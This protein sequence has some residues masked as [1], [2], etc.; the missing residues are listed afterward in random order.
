MPLDAGA[1]TVMGI[2]VASEPQRVQD[3]IA[4]MPQRFGLYEDLS[5]REN[6]DLY[7]SLHGISDEER[8]RRY[9]E[10]LQMTDLAAF[11]GRLAGNLSGGMKQKLRSCLYLN[12]LARASAAG[13]TDGRRRSAVAPRIVGNHRAPRARAKSQRP[14]EHLVSRRS[15]ALRSCLCAPRGQAPGERVARRSDQPGRRPQ[16]RGGASIGRTGTEPAS[17]TPRRPRNRRRGPRS[18]TRA[19]RQS[20]R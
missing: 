20:H 8:G 7:A 19:V 2:D 11:T 1:L 18:G 12:R 3:C 17:A 13:R 9:P 10:L 16:F 15:R 14:D 4:Y 5:V 6:L